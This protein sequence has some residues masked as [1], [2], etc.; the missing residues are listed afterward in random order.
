MGARRQSGRSWAAQAQPQ[1]PW[2]GIAGRM[3]RT[4]SSARGACREG[5]LFRDRRGA[6]QAPPQDVRMEH[7]VRDCRKKI[8]GESVT[9]TAC[10]ATKTRVDFHRRGFRLLRTYM[11]SRKLRSSWLWPSNRPLCCLS[12]GLLRGVR[13]RFRLMCF[14][15]LN[16]VEVR[17]SSENTRFPSPRAGAAN[18]RTR[19]ALPTPSAKP[20]PCRNEQM[21]RD[22]TL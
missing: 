11:R 20:I 19:L 13:K 16:E 17:P 12:R 10:S 7:E 21:G 5:R 1:S 9:Q 14:D 8:C 3:A 2:Y 15:R 18:P 4:S 6:R 22:L